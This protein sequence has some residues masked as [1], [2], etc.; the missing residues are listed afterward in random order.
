[1]TGQELRGA[2]WWGEDLGSDVDHERV[3]FA[4]GDLS[5][6][7]TRGA[8]FVGCTFRNVRFN[9]S[10]HHASAFV[11]CAFV[12]C[13]FFDARFEGCKLTGSTFESCELALLKVERGDWSFAGFTGATLEGVSFEDVRLRETDLTR[14][15]CARASFLGCDLS[16]SSFEGADLTDAVL[17]GSD[18][19]GLDPR[20]TKLAGAVVDS[21]QAEQIVTALGLTVVPG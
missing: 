14:A 11:N 1:M 19:T 8:R 13:N 12:G 16:G 17:T 3:L 15:R 9:V 2:D 5:E 10:S 20:T 21:R 6:V 7:T 4:D 18:L